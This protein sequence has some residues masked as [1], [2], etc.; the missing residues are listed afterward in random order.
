[1]KEWMIVQTWRKTNVVGMVDA[2]PNLSKS[3]ADRFFS[4]DTILISGVFH[5]EIPHFTVIIIVVVI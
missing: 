2:S 3:G 1:V 5:D 4:Q